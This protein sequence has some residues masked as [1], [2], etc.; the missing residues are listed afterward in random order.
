MEL[1][2][3]ELETHLTSQ[4]VGLQKTELQFKEQLANYDAL[5]RQLEAALENGREMVDKSVECLTISC[6]GFFKKKSLLY[7][8]FICPNTTATS[9]C[10][11]KIPSCMLFQ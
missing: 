3:K 10:V 7:N 4:E 1:Q 11:L 9:A 5:T 8:K 6:S 2:N